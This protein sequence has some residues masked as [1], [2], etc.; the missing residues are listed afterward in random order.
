MRIG[1]VVVLYNPNIQV[2]NNIKNYPKI[3]QLI[4][5]DNSLKNNENLFSSILSGN[6]VMYKPLFNNFGIAYALNLGI[7][8]LNDDIDFVITMDQDS[9]L[10]SRVISV[11]RNYI[12]SHDNVYALT[13]QYKTDRN[14]PKNMYGIN[15][16]NLSMQSGSLFNV[17]M[18]TK[19][20][21]FDE[22]LFL[23]VVDW[24]FFLRMRKHGYDLIR[25]NEA[26]LVHSPAQTDSKKILFKNIKYGVASPVRYYYQ[27]RNLLWVGKKYNSIK[28]YT[29]LLVKL[30]KI[31][32]LFNNKTQY[33]KYFNKG[34]RDAE[35]NRLGE[36][37]RG[38]LWKKN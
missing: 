31:L 20:G 22:K 19:I 18:F 9:N 12:L 2:L 7:K 14:T 32:I 24:E 15:K 28:L 34:I 29:N 38:N 21:Y 37:R 35:D 6:D 23:D 26:V 1:C 5:V 13:P 10:T 33:L 3:D 27:A 8:S 25:C 17:K 30:L 36:L 11:Y 4:L 16:V